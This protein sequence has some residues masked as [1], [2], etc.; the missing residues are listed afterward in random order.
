MIVSLEGKNA[1]VCG[2]TKGIGRAI[3]EEFA[4]SGATVTLVARDEETLKEVLSGLS[5][6]KGQKHKYIAA[7]FTNPDDLRRKIG[8]YVSQNT[9]VH[10]LV[11]N[12][13]GPKGGEI[14]NAG[15]KEFE[16]AFK[17]HLVCN[18][19]MTQALAD[20]MMKEG[21]GRIINIISTS[22]KQPIKGLGVS[23]TIR[24]AVASWSKTMAA[25]LG[26]YGITVNNLLPGATKTVRLEAIIKTKAEKTGKSEQ[27]VE[28][29]MRGEIPAGR[30]AEA[31][32][33]AYAA[34]FLA[35]DKAGYING[36]S[37]AVDGGRTG[38]L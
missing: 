5:T 1:V 15:T 7:D 20:G 35:S 19:I 10:I 22:V 32:E 33:L 11:N 30:F 25:E 29:E 21:Y 18:Q 34:A 4:E 31:A 13:G 8:V 27:E 26:K 2:S 16:D 12:T 3:A 23:N 14:I 9:S 24:G 36:V 17:M 38:C 28:Q 6:E 37:I